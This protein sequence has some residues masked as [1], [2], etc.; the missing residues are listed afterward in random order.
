VR[1]YRRCERQCGFTADDNRVEDAACM[2][3]S[4]E[5]RTACLHSMQQLLRAEPLRL[6]RSQ[7]DHGRHDD[8]YNDS[9]IADSAASASALV[10]MRVRAAS[11][12]G[13]GARSATHGSICMRAHS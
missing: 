9:L 11:M 12:S 10:R 4:L 13:A 6:T 2:H 7:D 3:R 1:T 5:K 8:V